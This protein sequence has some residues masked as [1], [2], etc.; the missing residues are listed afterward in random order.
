M[1]LKF[2]KISYETW[3][4][5]KAANITIRGVS[6]NSCTPIGE[7]TASIKSR[8]NAF[9][10]SLQ[11]FIMQNVAGTLPTVYP[12]ENIMKVI[13]SKEYADP[14]VCSARKIDMIVGTQVFFRLL[15]VGQIRPAGTDAIW[16]KTVFGW[17]LS[18]HITS[19]NPMHCLSATA[20]TFD[21]IQRQ[22]QKFW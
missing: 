6:G 1:P 8:L 3:L 22:V 13:N 20:S 19:T 18:G 11:F 15:C 5:Y 17:I 4:S 14:D 10:A 9:K 21:P 7:I 16:Q 2:V 12:E